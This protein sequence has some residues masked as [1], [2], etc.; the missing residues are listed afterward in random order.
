MNRAGEWG[1]TG[2]RP[3]FVVAFE[4]PGQALVGDRPLVAEPRE[5]VAPGSGS[6]FVA[7]E[8]VLRPRADRRP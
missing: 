8:R 2:S 3:V 4:P 7:S 1:E 5:Q 6:G